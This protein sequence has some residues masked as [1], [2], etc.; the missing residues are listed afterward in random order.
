MNPR[1]VTYPSADGAQ[2]AARNNLRREGTEPLND[3]RRKKA[4]A[5]QQTA[6]DVDRE[7]REKF[8]R[9]RA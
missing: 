4:A 2:A 5:A 9:D 1:D 8:A 7:V 3:V 6:A